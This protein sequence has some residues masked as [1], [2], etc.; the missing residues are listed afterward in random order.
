M[1]VQYECV[2]YPRVL[3][4]YAVK[5]LSYIAI[6]Y[7]HMHTVCNAGWTDQHIHGNTDGNTLAN[8]WTIVR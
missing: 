8:H 6:M 3:Q 7:I 1:N 5:C 4:I 2:C